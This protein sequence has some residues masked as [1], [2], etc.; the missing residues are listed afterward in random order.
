MNTLLIW[1]PKNYLRGKRSLFI[2][3]SW[4][5]FIKIAYQ[6][7]VS[8]IL[9]QKPF[10]RPNLEDSW[11]LETHSWT[12]LKGRKLRFFLETLTWSESME[13]IFYFSIFDF[14][15]WHCPPGKFGRQWKIFLFL[16]AFCPTDREV[17]VIV[18]WFFLYY[19]SY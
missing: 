19:F 12:I 10:P 7:T 15:C 17:G 6:I 18:R 13:S 16:K 14:L 2:P 11:I 4:G 3:V 9:Q 1:V 5:H 8:R